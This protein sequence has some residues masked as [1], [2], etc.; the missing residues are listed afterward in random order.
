MDFAYL[1]HYR[2]KSLD[3]YAKVLLDCMIGDHMLFWR[4]DGIEKSWAFLMPILEECIQ[5]SCAGT[6]LSFYSAGSWGPDAVGP[7]MNLLVDD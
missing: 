7:I 6:D 3:A 4:Q 5:C 1:E 2:G